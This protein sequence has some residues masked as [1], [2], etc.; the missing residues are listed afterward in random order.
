MSAGVSL[1]QA[2]PFALLVAGLFVSLALAGCLASAATAQSVQPDADA[3]AQSWDADARLVAII[4]L[5][6]RSAELA[7]MGLDWMS[8]EDEHWERA[9][10][11]PEPGNG[12][13]EVWVFSYHG[14]EDR[15]LH[16]VLDG[17]GEILDAF[18]EARLTDLLPVGDYQVDSDEAM[19]IAM[20]EN[21]GLQDARE[22]DSFGVMS[23]L[24]R[25]MEDYDPTWV[26][27][28]GFGDFREGAGGGFVVIDAMTGEVLFS[29]GGFR[30][31]QSGWDG[32][33][34]WDWDW[35]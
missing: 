17:K 21:E 5:E 30:S 6:G 23:M 20:S 14:S 25:P 13:A 18:E 9:E 15:A 1:K 24:A 7:S 19:S 8:D 27:M 31:W 22:R 2:A 29:H 10:A 33:W 28:G 3:Y 32:D 16:V 11:D 26:I 34:D 4:G 35:D 12:Q